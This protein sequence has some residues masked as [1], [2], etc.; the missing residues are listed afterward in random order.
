MFQRLFSKPLICILQ[1][2]AL[3]GHSFTGSYNASWYDQSK[4]FSGTTSVNTSLLKP[5]T[6]TR[7]MIH[8]AQQRSSKVP[9]FPWLSHFAILHKNRLMHWRHGISICICCFG[10]VDSHHVWCRSSSAVRWEV[11]GKWWHK[12]IYINGALVGLCAC[13]R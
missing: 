11:G 1:L 5:C 6:E 2:Q 8:E 7:S 13:C 10:F 9:R 3:T 12:W 4:Y